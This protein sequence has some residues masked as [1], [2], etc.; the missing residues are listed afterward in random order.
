MSVTLRKMAQ[1]VI[2]LES[3]GNSSNDS[4]LN[5]GY[6]MLFIRQ[7]A[8]KLLNGRMLERMAQDDRSN[9]QLMIASYEVDVQGDNPTKY[10]DLPDFYVNLPFNKGLHAIAPVDDP[11]NHFIP[12][13][14]PAVSMN[15]PCADLDPGQCSYWTKGMKVYFDG[16]QLDLSKVLVDLVVAAPDNVAADDSLPLYP[17]QQF[18]IIQM[19]RE[20]LKTVPLQDKVL[21]NNPDVGTKIRA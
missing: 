15:L 5:E 12:R 11:T 7:A 17:E 20:M 3:G 18:D 19:V 14:N 1:E 10:I 6:V 2:R 13:H 4:Q 9:L 16:D 21:D 8:N